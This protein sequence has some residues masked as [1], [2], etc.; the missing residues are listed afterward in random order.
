VVYS[1]GRSIK[2]QLGNGP[3]AAS[4]SSPSIVTALNNISIRKITCGAEH[5]AAVSGDGKLYLWGANMLG[6]CGSTNRESV[7]SPLL[8]DKLL[9]GRPLKVKDVACGETQTFII[10]GMIH[11]IVL[12]IYTESGELL[13]LGY[14]FG[15]D[16]GEVS[17][18]YKPDTPV[19]KPVNSLRGKTISRVSCGKRFCVVVVG[20]YKMNWRL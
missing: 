13:Y 11:T 16:S 3:G 5:C 8:I 17:P 12:L 15:E 19:F 18:R 7:L 2:G 14:C 20:M 1:W 9:D 6:Q 10:T 4:L